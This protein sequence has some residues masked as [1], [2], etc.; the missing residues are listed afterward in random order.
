MPIAHIRDRGFGNAVDTALDRVASQERRFWLHLDLDVLDDAV[1][2]AVDY[3]LPGGRMING[4]WALPSSLERSRDD[5][6]NDEALHN[7]KEDH[8]RRDSHDQRCQRVVPLIGV[9]AE[10]AEYGDRY[11]L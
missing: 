1:L 2:S 3:R 11:R 7:Q 10:K 5:A 9:L 8:D 6:A 4:T